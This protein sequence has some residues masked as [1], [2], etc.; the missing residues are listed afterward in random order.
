MKIIG[1]GFGRTGTTSLQLAIE[2]LGFGKCYHMEELLKNP[3]GV[4]YW[5]NAFQFCSF[6]HKFSY[7]K[8]YYLPFYFLYIIFPVRYTIHQR[9]LLESFEIL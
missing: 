8:K 6:P 9:M 5:K 2:K 7:I 4:K 1:A 3:E